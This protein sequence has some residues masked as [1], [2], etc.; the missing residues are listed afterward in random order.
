[1]NEEEQSAIITFANLLIRSVSDFFSASKITEIIGDNPV[2]E[3]FFNADKK[4]FF[5]KKRVSTFPLFFNSV[6]FQD[7]VA[8]IIDVLSKSSGFHFT[9]SRLE[10]IYTELGKLYSVEIINRII[11]PYIPEGYLEQHRV[12]YLS[13]EELEVRV[14]KKTKELERLNN[15]LEDKIK[16]RTIELKNL[17]K[18]QQESAK[19]LIRRDLEL[20]RANERLLELDQKKSEFVTIAAHQLRTPLSGI[21][22][23]F[24]ML[25]KKELGPLSDDQI[26]FIMKGYESNERM[27]NLVDDM[28][29]ADRIDSGKYFYAMRPVQILDL[30]DN[31][32]YE[33]APIARKNKISIEYESRPA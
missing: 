5:E 9:E 23:I 8:R 30:F 17:L 6:L 13:K 1:M 15:E 28:L 16:K 27:I 19:M 12:A 3:I 14:L 22:W 32:L 20:N 21:K 24:S 26:T 29:N 2:K 33:M 11:M 7:A 10:I 25:I 4:E 31:L 18:E